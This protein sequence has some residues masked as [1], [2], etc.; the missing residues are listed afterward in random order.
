[1][2]HVVQLLNS[3]LEGLSLIIVMRNVIELLLIE[4]SYLPPQ[5]WKYDARKLV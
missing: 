2:L 4:S 5:N 3:V 1:M